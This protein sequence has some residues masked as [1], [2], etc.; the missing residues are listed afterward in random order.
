MARVSNLHGF[1]P[2]SLYPADTNSDG[3]YPLAGLLL[4]GDTLFYGT[5]QDGG[6]FGTGTIFAV[7]T[8]GSGFTNL[9]TFTAGADGSSPTANLILSGDTPHGMRIRRQRRQRHAVL[10]HTDGSDFT[11]LHRFSGAADGGTLAPVWPYWA[12]LCMGQPNPA[13]NTTGRSS[14]STRMGPGFTT[15]YTFTGGADGSGPTGTR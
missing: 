12:P 4:S 10:L 8:D 13:A 2:A 7:K 15:I 6:T 1:L 9:Y 11:V 5:A 3:A 14:P